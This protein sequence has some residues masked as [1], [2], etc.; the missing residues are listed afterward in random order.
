[1]Q[2]HHQGKLCCNVVALGQAR[3]ALR[4]RTHT[5]THTHTQT[6][7]YIHTLT[8]TYTPHT[9]VIQSLSLWVQHHTKLGLAIYT[10]IYNIV[11]IILYIRW[12]YGN[13]GREITKYTVIYGAYIRF[14]PALLI[15]IMSAA[16]HRAHWSKTAQPLTSG[17]V[18][19]CV[20][21]IMIG[22]VLHTT[23]RAR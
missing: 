2:H 14:W 13:F 9:H 6:Y 18:V 22:A 15:N 7:A 4:A 21:T 5:H 8:N 11:Y 16:S 10:H 20:T 3:T 17:P 12:V 1:M 19:K 23:Y